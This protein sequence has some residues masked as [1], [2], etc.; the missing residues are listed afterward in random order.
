MGY[1]IKDF[2]FT[3]LSVHGLCSRFVG[4]NFKLLKLVHIT[5]FNSC[6]FC[7]L[8]NYVGALIISSL[9]YVPTCDSYNACIRGPSGVGVGGWGVG[10]GGSTIQRGIDAPVKRRRFKLFL[11]IKI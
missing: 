3:L 4:I 2:T 6:V 11:A 1:Q 8:N 7:T 10:G 5:S 9:S